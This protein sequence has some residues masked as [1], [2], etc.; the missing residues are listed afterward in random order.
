MSGTLSKR[1]QA[2]NEAILQELVHSVPGNDQCADCHARNPGM[3]H[4]LPMLLALVVQPF[5]NRDPC[6]RLGIMECTISFP[7]RPFVPLRPEMVH[8]N[9]CNCSWASS[10]VCAVPRYIESW[11]RTYPRSS[12]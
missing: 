9:P 12:R 7:R 5:A 11:A 8:A 4:A 1:Q 2:R 6:D 10:Y 3:H